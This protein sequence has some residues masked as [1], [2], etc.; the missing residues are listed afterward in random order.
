MNF[1]KEIKKFTKICYQP[2]IEKTDDLNYA[3]SKYYGNVWISNEDT[4]PVNE[5]GTFYTFIYQLDI[6]SL[7]EEYQ[8]KINKTGILQFFYDTS[9]HTEDNDHLVRIVEPNDNGQYFSQP[10]NQNKDHNYK[11]N[12]ASPQSL[13]IKEW[14]AHDDYPS[15]DESF[16]ELSELW[17]NIQEHEDFDDEKYSPILGDKLGGY[18]YFAQAGGSSEELIYQIQFDE[19]EEYDEKQFPSYA[20]CLVASDG[21][22]HLFINNDDE[23]DNTNMEHLFDFYW[24]CG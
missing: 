8:K 19:N 14:K 23:I 9:I 6:K 5:N 11:V 7:P 21:T 18:C 12:D 3:G 16:D 22:G 2:I 13:I 15:W 10:T 17:E 20:P 24:S 1:T 4:W